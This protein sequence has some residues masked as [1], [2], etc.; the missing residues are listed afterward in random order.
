MATPQEFLGADSAHLAG[1]DVNSPTVTAWYA[2]QA[3]VTLA[4]A[5]ATLITSPDLVCPPQSLSS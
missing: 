1:V 4:D 5:A 3:A 2:T